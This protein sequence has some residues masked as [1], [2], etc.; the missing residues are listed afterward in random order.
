M[1]EGQEPW[2]AIITGAIQMSL[3]ICAP[4]TTTYSV[5]TPTGSSEL[6]LDVQP[7]SFPSPKFFGK[8]LQG[9]PVF[10][11]AKTSRRNSNWETA[12]V[13]AYRKASWVFSLIYIYLSLWTLKHININT[14]Q[15]FHVS[16]RQI[17]SLSLATLLPSKLSLSLSSLDKP[18]GRKR[19]YGI[20]RSTIGSENHRILILV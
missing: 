10:L 16:N 7:N 4:P 2:L 11:E 20:L 9:W 6:S 12:R 1:K 19:L 15:M 17:V 13:S 3:L 14:R 5:P 18:Q 8:H